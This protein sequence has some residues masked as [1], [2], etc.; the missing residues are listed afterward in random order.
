MSRPP[1][2]PIPPG[3]MEEAPRGLVPAWNSEEVDESFEGFFQ[4]INPRE[5][6]GFQQAL[7][8]ASDK[9][10]REYLRQI[11]LP[12][13]RNRSCSS[14]AKI[15]DI[16]L[17][18]FIDFLRSSYHTQ[19]ISLSAARLP[20]IVSDMADDAMTQKEA[21]GRCDGWGFVNVSAEEMPIL[22]EGKPI[23]GGIRPMGQRWVRDCP[24]CDGTGKTSKPGDAH[25]RDKIL[26][27]NGISNKSTGVTVAINNNYSGH[28]IESAG[29]RLSAITFDIGADVIEG[30]DPASTDDRDR[31]LEGD[32]VEGE[33]L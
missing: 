4:P 15:M 18:E 13:N 31:I 25:A 12:K 5:N 20:A 2:N 19:A 14:I 24:K 8:A 29:Q 1:K 10:F 17:R 9:R 7:A 27:M 6:P 28:G 3:M 30:G 26:L 11:N 32:P 23:P 22:E 16:S 21:C 33:E